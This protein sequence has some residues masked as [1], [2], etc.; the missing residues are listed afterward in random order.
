MHLLSAHRT[1]IRQLCYEIAFAMASLS[2]II[3]VH[4]HAILAF[5]EAAPV[6]E[7]RKHRRSAE[8]QC[9]EK[10]CQETES[11]VEVPL[12]M[13]YRWPATPKHRAKQIFHL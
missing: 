12:R 6:G 10:G 2:K 3:D 8:G 9:R 1:G 4:S 13:L 11:K 5:G 7:G